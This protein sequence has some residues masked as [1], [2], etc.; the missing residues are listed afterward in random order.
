MLV[1][2]LARPR[3]SLE[4]GDSSVE[5]RL[6]RERGRSRL[7]YSDLMLTGHGM[8]GFVRVTSLWRGHNGDAHAVG[9]Q[10]PLPHGSRPGVSAS[11]CF[12]EN[13]R[14]AGSL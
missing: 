1:L 11:R 10:Q 12:A 5:Y 13:S 2:K 3:D 7:E 14:G 8:G 4:C 9:S 6:C